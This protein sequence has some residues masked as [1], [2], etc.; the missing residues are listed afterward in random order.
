MHHRFV[1]QTCALNQAQARAC[2]ALI[3]TSAYRCRTRGAA[4]TG[5]NDGNETRFPH[6]P[7]RRQRDWRAG[8][9]ARSRRRIAL[10]HR[11]LV[12]RR[13][14]AHRTD[15]TARSATGSRRCASG[16]PA[17][18][19]DI[20]YSVTAWWPCWA[21]LR[22]ETAGRSR[23]RKEKGGQ[24]QTHRPTLR[25]VLQQGDGFIGDS[26]SQRLLQQQPCFLGAETQVCRR[27]F[28]PAAGGRAVVPEAAADR[29]A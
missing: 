16:K 5:R 10:R 12:S 25:A 29:P 3:S 6:L 1:H 27:G 4:R 9:R 8:W 18:T 26:R 7:A 2:M 24:V 17:R 28:R 21:I 20:R 13:S 22:A 19:S 23:L 14:K 11:L 15:Q